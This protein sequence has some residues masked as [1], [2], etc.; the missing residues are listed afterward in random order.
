MGHFTGS[1]PENLLASP[2]PTE[3]QDGLPNLSDAQAQTVAGG[4]G[5]TR[6][7]CPN[8]RTIPRFLSEHWLS[9]SYPPWSRGPSN[10]TQTG[11]RPASGAAS[12]RPSFGPKC[13]AYGDLR[14]RCRYCEGR[15]VRNALTCERRCE[16]PMNSNASNLQPPTEITASYLRRASYPQSLA[17]A[18]RAV[19]SIK[20]LH[21][22]TMSQ[23]SNR[24]PVH[25]PDLV[26][27]EICWGRIDRNDARS[28]F[29][30]RGPLP[31]PRTK[32]TARRFR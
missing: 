5:G 23:T 24:Q 9:S 2:Y 16:V 19:V 8:G 4:C 10:R 14:R 3:L 26:R 7:P 28:Q 1:A 30:H 21:S 11:A 20:T 18:S 13:R 15:Q 12:L 29:E 25:E 22:R 32:R 17:R 27:C 6:T 31:H